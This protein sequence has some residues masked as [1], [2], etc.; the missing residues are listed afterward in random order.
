MQ[1]LLSLPLKS[2]SLRPTRLGRRPDSS[3]L[4]KARL[5]EEPPFRPLQS[6]SRLAREGYRYEK[7]VQKE[8][9]WR[10]PPP[11][12]LLVQPWIEWE[13]SDGSLHYSSPDLILLSGA[14]PGLLV[15]CKRTRCLDAE[16][17]LRFYRRLCGFVWPGRTWKLIA[18]CLRWSASGAAPLVLAPE[19]AGVESLSWWHFVPLKL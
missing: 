10:F 15:E 18:S 19:T 4:T 13:T 16:E 1:A 11:W 7:A 14:E 6:R 3:A 12:E 17:Q 5:I 8:L 9:R 2:V